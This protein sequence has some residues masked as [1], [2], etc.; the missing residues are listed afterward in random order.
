MDEGERG[1]R[2]RMTAEEQ[3]LKWGRKI[4]TG[5]EMDRD[6]DWERD[7]KISNRDI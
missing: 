5:R 6:I 4:E 2:E 7:H 1:E 3:E